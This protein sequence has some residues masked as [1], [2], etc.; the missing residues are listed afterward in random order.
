MSAPVL[1]VIFLLCASLLGASGVP[2]A[3]DVGGGVGVFATTSFRPRPIASSSVIFLSGQRGTLFFPFYL[4]CKSTK[5][6]EN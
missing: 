6:P 5:L 2:A 3:G 1:E 4:F